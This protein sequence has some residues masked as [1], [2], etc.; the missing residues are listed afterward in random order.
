MREILERLTD[1]RIVSPERHSTYEKRES[2]VRAHLCGGLAANRKGMLKAHVVVQAELH[3]A[4][5]PVL[6]MRIPSGIDQKA[7]P[8]KA[9]DCDGVDD[10]GR[11]IVSPARLA[12]RRYTTEKTDPSYRF[13][14]S[15]GTTNSFERSG[16]GDVDG[17]RGYGSLTL[18]MTGSSSDSTGWS[19][20][21]ETT[22]QRAIFYPSRPFLSLFF[23]SI[24]SRTTKNEL[25]APTWIH[26]WVKKSVGVEGS[27]FL[28]SKP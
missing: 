18:C 2:A 23:T 5:P 16:T 3:N 21:T 17:S 11:E 1:E 6:F 10:D 19:R 7:L 4:F 20:W 26:A 9:R 25:V 22:E 14:R 28:L 27:I 12:M 24:E 8:D 13:H 15:A